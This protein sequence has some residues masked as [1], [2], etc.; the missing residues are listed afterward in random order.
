VEGWVERGAYD[1]V[2]SGSGI[3]SYTE[4]FEAAPGGDQTVDVGW[5]VDASI[6]QAKLDSAVS[7]KL[8]TYYATLPAGTSW[9]DGTRIIIPNVTSDGYWTLRWS[10]G[11]TAWYFVGGTSSMVTHGTLSGGSSQT[12]TSTSDPMTAVT[13]HTVTLPNK[14][15][16][17]IRSEIDATSAGTGGGGYFFGVGTSATNAAT[18]R[19][20]D[21]HAQ[22]GHRTL[23]S[24][25]Q[26]IQTTATS[27]T[28][29]GYSRA[30]ANGTGSSVTVHSG[31]M[32]VTPT[33]LVP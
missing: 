7:A 16:Y 10:S 15:T 8:E 33:K 24:R 11:N 25:T 20:L 21:D 19:W 23:S 1:I 3:T 30:A 17:Q 31:S 9:T 6:T 13:G 22:T 2:I 29:A 12:I 26:T 5:L 28:L 32:I 4:P 18:Y 27:T 14:G